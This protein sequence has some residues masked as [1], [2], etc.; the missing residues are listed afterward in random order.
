MR[1]ITLFLLVK[2]PITALLF[3]ADIAAN[4]SK[5]RDIPM[6]N[7]MK[8]SRFRRKSVVD[9]LIAKSMINDAGLHGRTIAPKKKPKRNEERKGFFVIGAVTFGKN[10]PTSILKIRKILTMAKIPN[11]IGEIMPIALVNEVDRSFVN[12]SPNKNM[13]VIIPTVTMSPNCMIF[14]LGSSL[15]FES[16][17]AR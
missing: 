16:W 15:L 14:F 10:F 6:P 4:M 12:I 7:T 2:N 3:A 5:G 8:F 13:E 1:F 11:A 9:A 17:L